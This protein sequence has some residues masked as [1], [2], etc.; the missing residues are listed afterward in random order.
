MQPTRLFRAMVLLG[1]GIFCNLFFITYLISPRYCHRFVGYLEEEA[2]KTYTRL[3]DDIDR[4]DG[5]LREWR[6]KPAP[7]MAKKYWKLG[8]DATVRDV[9]LA[10]RADEAHHRYLTAISISSLTAAVL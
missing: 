3:I 4:E 10:I 9:I 5:P 2:V 8:N 7:D 6:K 1:Q